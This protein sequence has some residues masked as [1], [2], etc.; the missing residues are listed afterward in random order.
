MITIASSIVSV[1]GYAIR[2]NKKAAE[3]SGFLR[4]GRGLRPPGIRR[5]SLCYHGPHVYG[6]SRSGDVYEYVQKPA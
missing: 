3:I 4:S 6:R 1:W 2:S 5:I